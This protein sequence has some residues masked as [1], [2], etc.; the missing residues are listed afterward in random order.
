MEPT[1]NLCTPK[2][3]VSTKTINLPQENQNKTTKNR[4]TNDHISTVIDT[5]SNI[6]NTWYAS[7]QAKDHLTGKL[8]KNTE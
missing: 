5:L 2:S 1:T 3:P 8:S 4:Q 6:T 7:A